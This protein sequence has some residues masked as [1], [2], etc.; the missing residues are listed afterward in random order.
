MRAIDKY[1]FLAKLSLTPDLGFLIHTLL[2]E[3]SRGQIGGQNFTYF[4]TC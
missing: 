3:L 4:E 1:S 2:L